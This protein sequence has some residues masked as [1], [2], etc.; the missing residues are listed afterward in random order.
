MKKILIILLVLVFAFSCSSV[1]N[2]KGEKFIYKSQNRELLLTFSSDSV[3]T[4]KNTFFCDKIDDKFREITINATYKKQGN[5][6]IIKNINC[7]NNDCV[8][9]PSI[10]IPVQE[11]SDCVFLNNE[12]RKNKTVFDGKTYQNDYHKYGLVPNIDIDTMYISERK[13]IFTK[14]IRNGSFGFIFK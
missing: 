2:L 8:Y 5:M 7:K 3:C 13:I 12:G 11:N 9:P 1:K 6:I 14:K 10:E 4:I